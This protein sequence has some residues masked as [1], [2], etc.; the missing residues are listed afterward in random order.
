MPHGNTTRHIRHEAGVATERD[1][2]LMAWRHQPGLCTCFSRSRKSANRVTRT[3]STT[4]KHPVRSRACM[5]GVMTMPRGGCTSS[6]R[7]RCDWLKSATL[8]Q[9]AVWAAT[10]LGSQLVVVNQPSSRHLIVVYTP[11]PT[12]LA[13]TQHG[14]IQPLR[15]DT[16]APV[17][18]PSARRRPPR[19]RRALANPPRSHRP[20]IPLAVVPLPARHAGDPP[21][22]AL[23]AA[24]SQVRAQERGPVPA[25]CERH[26]R[27][28]PRF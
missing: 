28:V 19:V 24:R 27:P 23:G 21:R 8:G 4:A 10:T 25:R 22:P 11:P 13:Y 16:D 20:A 6:K 2:F 18:S 17:P 9:N 7:G 5:H 12:H 3:C 1:G 26:G 15:H 14:P